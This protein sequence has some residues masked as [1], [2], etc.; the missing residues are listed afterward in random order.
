MGGVKRNTAGSKK[1]YSRREKI[2]LV[3]CVCLFC[4]VLFC[5]VFFVFFIV[6]MLS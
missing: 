3:V 5:F 1:E 6:F 4:F 2:C